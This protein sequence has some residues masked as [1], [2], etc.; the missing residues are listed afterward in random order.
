VLNNK[1]TFEQMVEN[2]PWYIKLLPF[3]KRKILFK[4]ILN[5]LPKEPDSYRIYHIKYFLLKLSEVENLIKSYNKSIQDI[6]NNIKCINTSIE[7][8]KR[9]K[10]FY[11]LCLIMFL[12][13]L[14]K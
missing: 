3:V 2:L 13:K 11:F 8:Y 14:M 9:K 10:I 4:N 12:Q 1:K 6:D 7:N 5:I